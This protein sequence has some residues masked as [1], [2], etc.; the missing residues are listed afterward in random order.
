MSFLRSYKHDAPA[1]ESRGVFTRWRV[2][3]VSAAFCVIWPQS[4]FRIRAC[5]NRRSLHES[6]RLVVGRLSMSQ[7]RCAKKHT[8]GAMRDI[9]HAVFGDDRELSTDLTLWL[10]SRRCFD[11]RTSET[12]APDIC[13]SKSLSA[14]GRWDD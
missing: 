3:L 10:V 1:G 14:H 6:F 8:K 9:S 12:A 2:V 4:P 5:V 11:L 7:A 13:P